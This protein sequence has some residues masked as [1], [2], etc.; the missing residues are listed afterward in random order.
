MAILDIKKFNDPVLRKECQEIEKI[1]EKTKKLIVDMAQTMVENQG[2]GLAAPQVGI[3]EKVI[4]VATDLNG[5]RILEL[6]NPKIT[7]KSKEKEIGEEGCLS[8]PGI[9]LKINRA[10][11]VEVEGLDINGK[12]IKLK[13][14]GLLARVFQHEIDHLSGILFFHRL[15]ILEKAKFKLKYPHI[16]F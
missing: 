5:E 15:S 11:K 13:A 4:V 16:R 1:D 12:K 7:K 14:E 6:I 10:K 9:Y 8:F 2:I 3:S